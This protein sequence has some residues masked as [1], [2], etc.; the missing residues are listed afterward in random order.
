MKK[1][2]NIVMNQVTL[3]VQETPITFQE[4]KIQLYIDIYNTR[5]SYPLTMILLAIGDIKACF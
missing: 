1:P 3:V 4:V 2:T 5:I